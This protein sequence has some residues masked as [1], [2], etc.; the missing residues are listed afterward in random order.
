M[1]LTDIRHKISFIKDLVAYYRRLARYN[2][3]V[4]TE[5]DV[6]KMRYL[7]MRESHVFEKALSLK[8]IKKGFGREKAA[9]LVGHLKRYIDMPGSN[10]DISAYAVAILSKYVDCLAND[11]ITEPV[12]EADISLL[13]T[14]FPQLSATAGV[15]STTAKEISEAAAGDFR[16]LALSRHSIRYFSRRKVDRNKIVKALEIAA[17]TPSACNRQSWKTHVYFGK[18]AAA[19]VDWQGGARGV[20][21]YVNCAILVTADM[22]AFFAHEPFQVYVDGGLYAM[23]LINALHFSG[24]GTLPLS[25]G[26]NMDKLA[27][28]SDFG[29]P[30]NE[31][32]I[33]IICTGEM[34]ENVTYAISKRLSIENSNV[35]H[36]YEM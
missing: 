18:G 2:A 20:A 31:T 30:G 14:R 11:G 13:K 8:D 7:I 32:P 23:N 16:S 25:C 34:E 12:L 29:V 9:K 10:L 5:T 26:Y 17:M 33:V 3:S 4:S 27:S 15:A 21:R 22:R 35:F 24:L 1:K 28:I 6:E 19:L 36:E